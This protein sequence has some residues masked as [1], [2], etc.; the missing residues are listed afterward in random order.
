MELLR[1]RI[2]RLVCVSWCCSCRTS[3]NIE[4]PVLNFIRRHLCVFRRGGSSMCAL[5]GRVTDKEKNKDKIPFCANSCTMCIYTQLYTYLF[6]HLPPMSC[7]PSPPP[8][9]SQ[10]L[11]SPF[12]LHLLKI[13]HGPRH[14]RTRTLPRLIH[15]HKPPILR[16]P[17]HMH[18]IPHLTQHRPPRIRRIFFP[19]LLRL[20]IS[21]PRTANIRNRTRFL[22]QRIFNVFFTISC[23][24]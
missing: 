18:I 6:F 11:P 24:I 22:G 13:P 9:P 2:W 8:P 3:I 14:I 23:R 10:L 20:I 16:S 1:Q 7:D 17:L 21:R 15:R 4:P 12:F 5:P 19:A